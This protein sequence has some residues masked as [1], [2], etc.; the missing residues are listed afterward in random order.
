[1]VP[2]VIPLQFLLQV[3]GM[4]LGTFVVTNNFCQIKNAGIQ[5]VITFLDENGNLLDIYG[6]TNLTI[7]LQAPDGT[8]TSFPAQY[9]TNGLD[10]Q[11]F[12][13]TTATD[14]TEAG[15]WYVQGQVTIGGAVLTTALGQF[16]ANSN[17]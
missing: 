17:L 4:F 9:V 15:L 13:V 5:L 1:M 12:Y 8:Q 6:A 7:A 14:L 2:I 16:E 11:I 10:G 3:A